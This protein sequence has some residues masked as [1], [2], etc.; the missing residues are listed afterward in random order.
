MADIIDLLKRPGV[1]L[2][3]SLK[4]ILQS[5]KL[6][7][8]QKKTKT[9]MQI[10]I[11][12]YVTKHPEDAEKVR[13]LASSF[14]IDSKTKRQ[15]KSNSSQQTP[16]LTQ[17]PSSTSTHPSPT[18]S[19]PPPPPSQP[20]TQTDQLDSQR[21]L[22]IISQDNPVSID[23]SAMDIDSIIDHNK[24][25]LD[26]DNENDVNDSDKRQRFEYSRDDIRDL[27]SAQNRGYAIRE[28]YI[29]LLQE[30]VKE[31]K[32]TNELKQQEIDILREECDYQ[33]RQRNN[34]E[35]SLE[36]KTNEL[37]HTLRK[38]CGVIQDEIAQGMD[39]VTESV[40]TTQPKMV[41]SVPPNTAHHSKNPVTVGNALPSENGSL[42]R[43][44]LTQSNSQ[45]TKKPEQKRLPRSNRILLV[46]DSN[47]SDVN[48]S[49]LKPGT[50]VTK[51]LRYT[52]KLAT[53]KIPKVENPDHV[54]DVV[55]MVGLNDLK[56][57]ED[58]LTPEELQD[59][60]LDMLLAY[61]KQFKNARFHLTGVPPIDFIPH[62]EANEALQKLSKYTESNFISTKAC[63]DKTT[64]RL[65]PHLMRDRLHYNDW[66]IK[67]IAKG[68]K[69]SLF[70]SANR[71][72]TKLAILNGKKDSI[73]KNNKND[74]GTMSDP[75]STLGI[76][77]IELDDSSI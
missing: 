40:T 6:D 66:G 41:S 36:T 2:N 4:Q 50:R 59:S 31:L 68:I 69:K 48:P 55:F 38:F 77:V 35:Q 33:K 67:T 12:D 34:V 58:P 14:L 28:K 11:S 1:C 3:E 65:R 71:E 15:S 37:D 27:I 19:S 10:E 63:L 23:S 20:S 70:S 13:K 52:T 7:T 26:L 53:E 29:S 46:H 57:R 21:D 43:A 24:Q 74:Q 54:E 49:L 62:K 32:R 25:K 18:P 22:F 51:A 76:E 9:E 16:P 5:L 39:K 42:P 8:T 56:D 45:T 75:D 60:A 61:Q 44:D 47:G 17:P 64:K 30:E 72:S 73:I